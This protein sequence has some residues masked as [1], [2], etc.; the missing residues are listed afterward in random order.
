[1]ISF[2]TQLLTAI[3]S[4]VAMNTYA[5]IG[6]ASVDGVDCSASK[7]IADAV[8]LESGSTIEVGY[9]VSITHSANVKLVLMNEGENTVLVENLPDVL[10][11]T[12]VELT[13]PNVECQSC[14]I[15]VQQSGYTGTANIVLS[16]SGWVSMTDPGD[17]MMEPDLDPGVTPSVDTVTGSVASGGKKGGAMDWPVLLFGLVCAL[18]CATL[19]RHGV[20]KQRAAS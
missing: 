1:M 20:K 12:E 18:Y 16:N 4:C 11:L 13:L 5:H 2:K 6:L 15:Q 10:G 3:L 8:H 17:T 19:V 9:R 14:S 7:C